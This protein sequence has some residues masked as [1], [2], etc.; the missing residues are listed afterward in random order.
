MWNGTGVAIK[1][2][3]VPTDKTEYIAQEINIL[4]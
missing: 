1:T 2:V 3:D 4:M